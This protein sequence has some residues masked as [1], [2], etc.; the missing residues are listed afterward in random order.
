M[1]L[2]DK[3]LDMLYEMSEIHFEW[4]RMH[5]PEL[6]TTYADVLKLNHKK[7]LNLTEGCLD[8]SEEILDFIFTKIIK[9]YKKMLELEIK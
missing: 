5:S 6:N 7:M 8:C 1:E 2:T 4:F 9:D 3:Q